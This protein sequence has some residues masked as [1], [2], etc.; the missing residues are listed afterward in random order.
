M[1][2]ARE[3]KPKHHYAEFAPDQA[4][5]IRLKRSL[6][7]RRSKKNDNATLPSSN[8][9]SD[10]MAPSFGS[11]EMAPSAAG[12]GFGPPVSFVR[13]VTTVARLMRTCRN[14]SH[15]LLFSYIAPQAAIALDFGELPS[16]LSLRVEDS[17]AAAQ[18]RRQSHPAPA[19]L[20]TVAFHSSRGDGRACQLF[21]KPQEDR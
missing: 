7:S 4:P 19:S 17:R 5:G 6:R 2:Q 14:P 15:Q 13:N 16:G 20:R 11:D 9:G 21:H 10:E 18:T 12:G 1:F 8:F 3:H